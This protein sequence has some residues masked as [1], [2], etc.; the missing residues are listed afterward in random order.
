MELVSLVKLPKFLKLPNVFFALGVDWVYNKK[1]GRI[2]FRFGAQDE[3]R[4]H[5]GLRPPPPQSGV[6][7]NFTTWAIP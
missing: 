5:T 7:T 3:T 2:T 4:T 1:N 6:S